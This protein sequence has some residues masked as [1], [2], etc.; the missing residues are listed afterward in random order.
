MNATLEN[1]TAA[2]KELDKR[3]EDIRRFVEAHS[4]T[5]YRAGN[6]LAIEIPWNNVKDGSTGVEVEYVDSF[7]AARWALGY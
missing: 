4:F 7:R 5:T 2:A 3:L 1:A 6:R